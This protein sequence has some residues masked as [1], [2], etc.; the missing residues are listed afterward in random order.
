MINIPKPIQK[1]PLSHC[2]IGF[3]IFLVASLVFGSI[4]HNIE[5]KAVEEYLDTNFEQLYNSA[6]KDGFD[7]GYNEGFGVGSD[8][9][10]TEAEISIH[11]ESCGVSYNPHSTFN[12][13]FGLC[14]DCGRASLTDCAFCGNT[15][16]I[17][18]EHSFF[19]VCPSCLGAALETTNLEEYLVT[20]NENR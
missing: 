3:A 8:N 13:G 1:T 17:W 5:E 2:L 6:Y 19:A 4:V 9:S 18:S 14:N 16:F 7:D 20:F 15:T 10:L 11:C 12:F